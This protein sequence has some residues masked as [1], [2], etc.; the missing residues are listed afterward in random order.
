MHNQTMEKLHQMRL[1]GMAAAIR[2]QLDTPA[3]SDLSFGERMR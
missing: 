3:T 2:E 1:A